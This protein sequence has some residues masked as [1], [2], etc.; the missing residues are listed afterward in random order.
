MIYT[1]F[2]SNTEI[3]RH[4]DMYCKIKISIWAPTDALVDAEIPELAPTRELLFGYKHNSD[5]QTYILNYNKNV[6]AHLEPN[7]VAELIHLLAGDRIPVLMCYERPSAFCH[8]HLVADWLNY[9]NIECREL[10]GVPAYDYA[11]R[12]YVWNEV[13]SA[14]N[15]YKR[16]TRAL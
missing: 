7:E 13:L 10:Y 9:H 2:Y 15:N 6:L 8:R 1:S 3:R 12:G 14:D 11:Q 16:I 5:E 4:P